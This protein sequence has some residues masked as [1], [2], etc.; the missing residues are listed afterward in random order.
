LLCFIRFDYQRPSEKVLVI[1]NFDR[2]PQYIDMG[3]I[4]IKRLAERSQWVDLY[5]SRIATQYDDR[6][7]LQPYQ[8][9]WLT[10]R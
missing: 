10:E 2:N 9:Y 4:G 8:F 6:L 1:F 3:A 5:S 7:V